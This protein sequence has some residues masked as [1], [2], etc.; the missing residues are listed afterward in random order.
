MAVNVNDLMELATEFSNSPEEPKIRISIHKSYY[1]AY[2]SCLQYVV[3]LT[4]STE[5][6]NGI[7]HIGL[8]EKLYREFGRIGMRLSILLDG[9]KRERH[10]ADYE[11]LETIHKERA[12]ESLR[13]L[14]TLLEI[15]E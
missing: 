2:H 12:E 7:T 14:H 13:H 8:S 15:I 9:M 5:A 1:C 10:K 11:L 4:G 6:I 3:K